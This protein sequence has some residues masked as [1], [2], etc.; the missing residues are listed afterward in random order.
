M[1]INW[2]VKKGAA[3]EQE[4]GKIKDK[5]R[6]VIR[7]AIFFLS[8]VRVA[9]RVKTKLLKE[10]ARTIAGNGNYTSQK[11]E[12]KDFYIISGIP[13]KL[14]FISFD[15][16]PVFIF[17]TETQFQTHLW[18]LYYNFRAMLSYT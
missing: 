6:G 2:Y 7:A 3:Y 8:S 5:G 4:G 10:T 1:G 17:V 13:D 9:L 16:H 18:N 14:I 12:M 15:V 11:K